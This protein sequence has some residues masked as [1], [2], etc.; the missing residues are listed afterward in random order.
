[1]KIFTS[2]L[3]LFVS[4]ITFGQS[5]LA[6]KIRQLENAGEQ[7]T[8]FAP[9]IATGTNIAAHDAYAEE[10]LYF[11][12]DPAQLQAMINARAPFVELTMPGLYDTYTLQ[13]FPSSIFADGFQ[14]TGP[15]GVLPYDPYATSVAYRGIIKG[16]DASLVAVS[17]FADHIE[18]VIS[19]PEK[20]NVVFA[21]VKDAG[22]HVLYDDRSLLL[23]N[24][25][26]CA[27]QDPEQMEW[28]RSETEA[29][30]GALDPCVKV[31]IEAD[32]EMFED[33]GGATQAA[34]YIV[35]FFNV[36]STLYFN[37]SI[38]TVISEIFV[39]NEPD[40]YPT[41]SSFDALDYFTDYR[42][43]F[44]GDLAHLVTFDDENLGGVAWV[45][46]LC[47]SSYSYAYSNIYN[48]FSDFPVY[49]WTVEV[50]THEMGH[51]LGSPH[52]Q[53]CDWP[54]GAIDNCW[55]TEGGCPP[56]PAPVDGGTIMSYCH[57]TGYGINF[58]NG[59]GPLPGDLIRD[60]VTAAACLGACDL[61]PIND[62]PCAATEIP[63]N[64]SCVLVSGSNVGAINSVVPTVT[65]DGLS[66]GDV[67]FTLTVGPEGYVII[68]TDDGDVIDDMGM[69]LY[70]GTCTDLGNIPGGCV[71]DG[72]TYGPLMPG[73]V[74]EAPP[75]T[76]I[77]IRLWEVNNDAF[78][79][80]SICAYTEC[81]ASEVP[82]GLIAA[83]TILCAGEST[84]LTL[85]GGALGSMANWNW[86][87]DDCAGTLV[88]TDNTLS[89]TPAAT[90]TY[91]LNATGV[92][93][94]TDC[95][96]LTVEVAPVPATPEIVIGDCSLETEWV[97][98][99]V[100]TWYFEGEL[101]E[102][103]TGN[104]LLF[105]T[106]GEY[107]VT[108]TT[109][110]GCSATSEAVL[111]DC[112]QTSIEAFN[113]SAVQL[114]TNPADGMLSMMATD[115]TGEIHV[116]LYTITGQL[117]QEWPGTMIQAGEVIQLPLQ[118]AAGLYHLHI[119]GKQ[120]LQEE[121]VVIK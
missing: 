109:Y 28:K 96:S 29:K 105:D 75:G 81:V 106:P 114:L 44:N 40:P 47:V 87:T 72:S 76:D 39:W 51:N 98:G 53:N 20:G 15:N 95:V 43:D 89:V 8:Y 85:D 116:Q 26:E 108:I 56:G 80:F 25:I 35:S 16:D 50:F 38:T 64:E 32:Y 5:P 102:D 45:D 67:W 21:P 118:V 30:G 46:V 115:H 36:V 90:T 107:T 55:T 2:V 121:M 1:M 110:G 84:T 54:G 103:E 60:E 111:A 117:A 14:L 34:D 66:E 48:Y 23:N 101:I 3:L 62:W 58:A 71:P 59:F 100:Y 31:Y 86:Y 69:R 83:D 70:Y 52:T 65:C 7:P 19:S 112:E 99:A 37:E 93:D 120:L 74:L 42:D 119:T 78:G 104:V 88:S 33:E 94:T 92:C 17:V 91:Y 61:P 10:R 97:D 6:D 27:A 68:E 49:S 12:V 4:V 77:F 24:P 63:V 13:L 22:I 18:G 82:A 9:C 57:L 73:F 113:T 11:T 41:G 79:D